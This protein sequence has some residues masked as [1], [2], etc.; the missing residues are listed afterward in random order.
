[1]SVSH[2]SKPSFTILVEN[3]WTDV[4]VNFLNL[5][6]SAHKNVLELQFFLLIGLDQDSL[7]VVSQGLSPSDTQYN[8]I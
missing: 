1:M 7:I 3:I 5:S 2:A 6:P 4:K 8:I